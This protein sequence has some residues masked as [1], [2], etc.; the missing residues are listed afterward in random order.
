MANAQYS[1]EALERRRKANREW[2]RTHL[3]YVREKRARR[4]RAV[5]I[6]AVGSPELSAQKS[7]LLAARNRARARPIEERFWAKVD[8]TG[9]CWLWQGAYDRGGYGFFENKRAHRLAWIWTNGP[10]PDGLHLDH[11]CYVRNCVNSDHLE[12]VT[13]QEN[14]HRERLRNSRL[15]KGT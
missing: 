13:P 1:P 10:I 2:Y 9:E 14:I 11:L 8:K 3:D 12:P 6:P 15:K 7:A 5:G 4:R